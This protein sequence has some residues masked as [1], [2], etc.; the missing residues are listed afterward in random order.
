MHYVHQCLIK[1]QLKGGYCFVYSL[2]TETPILKWIK[3]ALI[4]Q[5]KFS[6]NKKIN[7]NTVH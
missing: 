6:E 2:Y 7:K 1:N 3:C 5:G 4:I